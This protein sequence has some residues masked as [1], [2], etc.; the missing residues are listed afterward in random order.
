[1]RASLRRGWRRGVRVSSIALYPT[2]SPN[3]LRASVKARERPGPAPDKHSHNPQG[4]CPASVCF[5]NA[6]VILSSDSNEE[7]STRCSEGVFK[8]GWGQKQRR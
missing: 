6:K 1:M 4:W 7:E 3:P 8:E 5:R 2:A